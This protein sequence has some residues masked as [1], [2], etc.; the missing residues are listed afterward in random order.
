MAI[1]PKNTNIDH[2]LKNINQA[3][4][5]GCLLYGPNVLLSNFRFEMIAKSI[6]A[7]LQ[8][9]FLVTNLNNQQIKE[10]CYILLDEF[11]SIPMFG[12]RKLIIIRNPEKDFTTAIKALFATNNY[13]SKSNNFIL[14]FAD[15]LD[16][17]S[18]L[19]K[20]I[21]DDPYFIAIPAYVEKES[22]INQFITFE[23]K[24]HQIKA[25]FSVVKAIAQ[26]VGKNRQIISTEIN[27]I[28]TYLA[29]NKNL[30]LLTLQKLLGENQASSGENL[31]QNFVLDFAFKKYHLCLENMAKIYNEHKEFIMLTRVLITYFSKL[32]FGKIAW[33]VYKKPLPQIALE[34]KVFYPMQEPFLQHLQQLNLQF[35]NVMLQNLEELELNLKQSKIGDC[36]VFASFLQNLTK[37][38][39]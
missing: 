2:Y 37:Q 7:N 35:I 26:N 21:E 1:L 24:K 29:E 17:D 22:D 16:K 9:Q 12:E 30:N 39:L 19:R 34:E 20:T 31:V 36:L 5:S 8:D 27:K 14:V 38:H 13:A 11:F 6:V 25:D 10:D 18:S 23:L 32:Y 4:I 28:A 33:Q 15:E 3:K